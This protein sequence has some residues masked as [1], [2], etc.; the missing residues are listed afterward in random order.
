MPGIAK[1]L[2]DLVGN[3]P[4]LE[5][6]NFNESKKLGARVIAKL[7]SFNPLSSVK[8]RIGY[9]MIKDTEEQGLINHD[10]VI[11]E[12]TSGNTGEGYLS[13]PLFDGD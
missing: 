6:V 4:L 7:E 2:T 1:H 5:L 8:D 13:T 10:T 12:P 11:I 9:A 3:T